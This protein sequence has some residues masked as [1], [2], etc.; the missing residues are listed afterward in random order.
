MKLKLSILSIGLLLFIA[1]GDTASQNK[2]TN[3]NT[4]TTASPTPTPAQKDELAEAK[5][6]FTETCSICHKESGEGGTAEVGKKTIKNIPSFKTDKSKAKPDDKLINYITNG[7]D[8][9]PSFKD[10]LSAE[11]IKSFV[12]FIR[13]EFQGK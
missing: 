3:N 13:K 10:E 9:M 2:T 4:P 6:I 7:D 1:C 8:D 12:K 5:T 11:Q